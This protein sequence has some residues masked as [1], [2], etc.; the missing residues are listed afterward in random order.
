MKWKVHDRLHAGQFVIHR[1]IE[2]NNKQCV[3]KLIYYVVYST[4]N[5]SSD[6]LYIWY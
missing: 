1:L 6:I 4:L 3:F 2:V 5:L